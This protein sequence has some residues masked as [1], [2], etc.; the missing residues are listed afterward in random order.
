[1]KSQNNVGII[2]IKYHFDSLVITVVLHEKP[3]N[4]VLKKKSL[5]LI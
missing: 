4:F 3:E 5:K 2:K 1:M